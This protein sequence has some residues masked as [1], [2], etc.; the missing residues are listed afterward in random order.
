MADPRRTRLDQPVTPRSGLPR[1]HYDP[2][3]FGRLSERIARFL[4]TGRFLVYLTLFVTL[5]L[6]WNTFA[7]DDLQFDPKALNYT[8]LTRLSEG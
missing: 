3:A 7:P 5:W 4:G 2:E 8:L 1:P 6:L